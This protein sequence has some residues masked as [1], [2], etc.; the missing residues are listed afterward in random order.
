MALLNQSTGTCK[1]T[2]NRITNIRIS[3]RLRL[4]RGQGKH[5]A[6]R[7]V[8][9]ISQQG[10][11][12]TSLLPPTASPQKR[13]SGKLHQSKQCIK[14]VTKITGGEPQI[15]GHGPPKTRMN[16]NV[17]YIKRDIRL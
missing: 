6:A 8:A 16:S 3:G 17:G 9:K 11:N 4:M 13:G 5:R 1:S 14:L 7:R 2:C 15:N 12:T 10:A